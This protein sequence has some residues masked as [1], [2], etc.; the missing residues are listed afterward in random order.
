M[1]IP[2]S[3][4]EFSK[5]GLDFYFVL[6]GLVW[7]QATSKFW[8]LRNS[9]FGPICILSI[10][11]RPPGSKWQSHRVSMGI[12]LSSEKKLV[13]MV[14]PNRLH[15]IPTVSRHSHWAMIPNT[16]TAATQKWIKMG[17]SW[18]RT[19]PVHHPFRTM[20]SSLTIH[21]GVSS[22]LGNPDIYHKP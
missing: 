11:F 19:S 22:I 12:S 10:I 21:L 14:H 4:L 20:G 8:S 18:N 17:L 16:S 2:F 13:S 7:K 5:R 1:S 9:F 3:P 15:K 6:C